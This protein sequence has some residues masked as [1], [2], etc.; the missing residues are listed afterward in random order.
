MNQIILYEKVNQQKLNQVLHCDNI[1]FDSTND[2]LKWFKQ[3][4]SNL[5]KYNHIKDEKN[6]KKKIIYKQINS[7]GRYYSSNGYQGFQKEVRKYLSNEYYDDADIE[8]CHPVILEQL[9]IKNNINP[10]E[11]LKSYNSDRDKFIKEYNLNSKLDFIKIINNDILFDNR[12]QKIHSLIYSKLLPILKSENPGLYKYIKTIKSKKLNYDG[13]FISHYLQIIENQI[14]L[15]IYKELQ[16]LNFTVGALCFD[17]CMIEKDSRLNKE[18]LITLQN[19][20]KKESGY[21]IVL[22]FKSMETEWVP[23]KNDII[24]DSNNIE[25]EVLTFSR[26]FVED[27][28][29][30]NKEG[31]IDELNLAQ[32]T[33]YLNNFICSFDSPLTYGYRNSTDKQFSFTSKDKL[34]DRIGSNLYYWKISD[35]RLQYQKV[36]F[37]LNDSDPIL[38][39]NVYNLYVRPPNKKPNCELKLELIAPKFYNYLFEIICDSNKD[40]Y[41]CLLN[42]I[43]KIAQ[44]GSSEMCLV[45][46]GR[47]GTGKSTLSKILA[48]IVGEDDEQYYNK[49]DSIEDLKS[50]FNS[51]MMTSIITTIEE[52]PVDSGNYH[53]IHSKLKTLITEKNMNYEKKGIDSFKGKSN[54]NFILNTNEIHP[55]PATKDNRRFIISKVSDK[56]RGNRQT[57]FIPLDQEIKEKIQEIR[58]FFNNFKFVDDIDSIRPITEAE[59]KLI[60]LT[61]KPHEIFLKDLILVGNKFDDSRKFNDIYDDYKS[62]CSKQEQKSLRKD[63]FK[64]YL[65]Q[66][67][68]DY[69][70]C[71]SNGD[72]F[73]YVFQSGE[74]ID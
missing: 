6:G 3:F 20:V 64:G 44:K 48:Y 2:D 30:L 14:L 60:E 61:T 46:M 26:R 17:G 59:K 37:I 47:M 72:D 24:F 1:P 40:L 51:N 36:V 39:T 29:V 15:I 11:D 23:M 71:R 18:L 22:K 10:S 28:I 21:D 5:L 45:L 57:Y 52:L 32:L 70:R 16:S 49:F 13:S 73:Y 58:Y 63:I 7:F 54:N 43:S 12:F 69:K 19:K 27:F 9:L 4:K 67:G 50:R 34:S 62:F 33:N 41:I 74:N 31:D 8:N 66:F 55:V 56:Q 68:L 38:K 53:S 25:N 42:Y 35:D 65:D